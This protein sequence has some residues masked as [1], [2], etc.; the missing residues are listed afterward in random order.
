MASTRRDRSVVTGLDLEEPCGSCLGAGYYRGRE[1]PVRCDV[2]K[3]AGFIPT[4]FGERILDLLRHNFGPMLQDAQETGPRE[5]KGEGD[6]H[7]IWRIRSG[8]HREYK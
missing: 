3:G 8:E 6:S 5:V 4:E 1:G 7:Q 2:C